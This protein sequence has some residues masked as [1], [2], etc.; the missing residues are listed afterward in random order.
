MNDSLL[1]FLIQQVETGK[2]ELIMIS[3][4]IVVAAGLLL[5]FIRRILGGQSG[6]FYSESDGGNDNSLARRLKE[7]EKET[8]KI[9]SELSGEIF[10]NTRDKIDR[11]INSY[12][13]TELSDLT[14]K[15]L[16]ESGVLESKLVKSFESKVIEQLD[17]Y[18][19][20]IDPKDIAILKL[21]HD[22]DS[23]KKYADEQLVQTLEQERRSSGL[24]KSVMI[25]LFVMVNLG[26]F[27]LYLVSGSD[28][29]QYAALSLSGLYVSLAAFIIYIFR[30]SNARTSVLLAIK[31]D[32]GKQLTA[33]DYAVTA[34]EG[35]SLSGND[36]EYIRMLLSNHAE[37]EKGTNH[38]YEVILKGISGS[39]IQFKGGKMSLGK[40]DGGSNK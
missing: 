2:F 22:L 12:L 10:K 27:V 23:R 18:L 34:K 31:E 16:D 8:K 17:A 21:K 14:E 6:F 40:S 3:I 24:L 13:D 30:A 32:M 39:N 11:E 9:K 36:I 37:R 38:P 26:L 20:E 28:L 5:S 35:G 1:Q 4:A 15:K 25:N 7:L 19:S 33:Y 29:N